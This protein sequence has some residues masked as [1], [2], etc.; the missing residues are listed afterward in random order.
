[1]KAADQLRAKGHEVA[2]FVKFLED[3]G[4][5]FRL[6]DEL[7]WMRF[8]GMVMP[9]FNRFVVTTVGDTIYLP[10]DFTKGRGKTDVIAT[11]AHEYVHV[12]DGR[13]SKFF[14]PTYVMPQALGALGFLALLSF[15]FPVMKWFTLA[16]LF[17]LPL[18]SPFR[19]HW[20]LR[21][22][23]MSMAAEIWMKGRL[24]PDTYDSIL[25]V[26]RGTTYWMYVPKSVLAKMLARQLRK[27]ESGDI[28]A[29]SLFA[30]VQM[31]LVENRLVKN[32]SFPSPPA[33]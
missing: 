2:L 27:V 1:M 3:R 7:W 20:E 9:D 8:V 31:F 29:D 21:G 18:P 15:L 12:K 10:R 6:K 28:L 30:E 4:V 13:K 26:L 23:T 17:F 25:K 33:K 32:T 11:L 24:A 14:L 5:K 19:L 16:F 22:Y